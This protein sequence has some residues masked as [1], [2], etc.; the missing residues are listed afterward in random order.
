MTESLAN[1]YR[2]EG[3]ILLKGLYDQSGLQRI[4]REIDR[5]RFIHPELCT[6]EDENEG[7]RERVLHKIS[8]FCE[9][10]STFLE[11]AFHPELK[12]AMNELSGEVYLCTDKINFKVPG[13]RGFYPHQ[14]MSGEWQFYVPNIINVFIALDR[15]DTENSC[16]EVSPGNHRRGLLGP[17]MGAIEEKHLEG[18]EWIP[19]IQEPG[20]VLIF[21]GFLPHRSAPNTSDRTR[22]ILIYT[23]TRKEDGDIRNKFLGK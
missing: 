18:M 12:Q 7:N 13:A 15:S 19:I 21:D 10:S 16:L 20:D 17:Y 3:Y 23:Y 4:D 1:R 2:E 14:D 8:H 9:Y 11:A 22:R 5:L 6:F